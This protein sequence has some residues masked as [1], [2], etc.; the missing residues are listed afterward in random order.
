VAPAIYTTGN[1]DTWE[2]ISQKTGVSVQKLKE[3]NS[4]IPSGSSLPPGQM[5]RLK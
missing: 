5:I 4:P 3:V 1:D 2:T